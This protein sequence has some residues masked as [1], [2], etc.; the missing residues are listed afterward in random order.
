MRWLLVFF[1]AGIF[2]SSFGSSLTGINNCQELQ[3]INSNLNEDYYLV[4]DIDCSA[5]IGWNSGSG[6]ISLGPFNRNFDGNG[7]VITGLFIR[8]LDN[9]GNPVVCPDNLGNPVVCPKT[10]LFDYVG[11]ASEIKDVGLVGI[12]ITPFFGSAGGLVNINEG[13]IYNSYTSGE[14]NASFGSAGG[15]VGI[16][17]GLINNSYSNVNISAYESSGGLVFKNMGTIVYSY[18]TGNL[19]NPGGGLGKAIGGLV[20]FN[21]DGYSYGYY[22]AFINWSYATGNLRGFGDLGGLVGFNEGTIHESYAL[23]NVSNL[24]AIGIG[25]SGGFVGRNYWHIYNSY[26]RGNV[27]CSNTQSDIV[28]GGFVGENA[29]EISEY[30]LIDRGNILNSYSTGN[31]EFYGV[32]LWGDCINLGNCAEK[33]PSAIEHSFWD[34]DKSGDLSI[35]LLTSSFCFLQGNTTTQMKKRATFENEGWDFDNIWMI[36]EDVDYPILSFS[37]GLPSEPRPFV[38]WMDTSYNE[39]SAAKVGQTVRLIFNNTGYISPAW[40]F[41]F[42]IYEY[43]GAT[44]KE[45]TKKSGNVYPG[46]N[47]VVH[48][49]ILQS[50]LSPTSDFDNFRFDVNDSDGATYT[51]PDLKIRLVR[52]EDI[53]GDEIGGFTGVDARINDTV[54]ISFYNTGYSTGTTVWF[55]IYEDDSLLNSDDEIRNISAVVDSSGNAVAIWDVTLAD[56]NKSEINDYTNFRFEVYDNLGDLFPSGFLVVD[57][58]Q[59]TSSNSLYWADQNLNQIGFAELGDTVKMVYENPSLVVGETD[60][61]HVYEDDVALDDNIADIAGKV[62]VAGMMTADWMITEDDLDKTLLDYGEFKF[63]VRGIDSDELSISSSEDDDSL[64]VT[65][66]SPLCGEDFAVGE[67]L[68]LIVSAVDFDDVID[69]KLSIYDSD[70]ILENS[71]NFSNGVL[72]I[73]YSFNDSGNFQLV[74]LADNTRGKKARVISNIMVIDQ[75]FDAVYVAACISWPK[76]FSN[77]NTAEVYFNA[78]NTM[79]IRHIGGSNIE[80]GKSE[81]NFYWVFSDGQT[82][83]YIDGSNVLA[84]NFYKR[85]QKAGNNWATLRVEVVD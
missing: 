29:A 53:S 43:D 37:L 68:N 15:L 16:N 83:P 34:V 27:F 12:D 22:P 23:G 3:D 17:W 36:D 74:A 59:T 77:I 42:R 71:Y 1:L 41:P 40:V 82:N 28:G 6:F 60:N 70:G 8:S 44:S 49:N 61:F 33:W 7:F 52:W 85:F 80:I 67:N 50:E 45:I 62:N 54:K 38:K 39:I 57:Y 18:A 11:S 48:W 76:D 13:D 21:G 81:I 20:G 25:A 46:G 72:N 9:L 69:G 64:D 2:S 30:P 65:I 66:D 14:I 47:F 78:T 24:M 31:L 84:Y 51:S 63:N 35:C 26:S 56:I 10:G 4:N 32:D 73:P 75:D 5:T 55:R 79:G 19:M 58:F